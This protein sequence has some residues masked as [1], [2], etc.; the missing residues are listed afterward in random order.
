MT[1]RSGSETRRKCKL[2]MVRVTP[3][4]FE[5][6][7]QRAKDAGLTLP[8]Y[9]RSCGMSRQIKSAVEAQVVN[10]LRRLGGLQKHLFKEGGGQLSKEYSEVLVALTHAIA[11]IAV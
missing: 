4:D 11:R 2:V 10:E 9:L 8:E 6:L 1:G 3:E 5:A 7:G